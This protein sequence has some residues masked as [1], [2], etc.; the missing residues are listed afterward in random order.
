LPIGRPSSRRLDT[1]IGAGGR[2]VSAGE[3]QLLGLA[4]V[5]LRDPGLVIL[6]EPSSRLDLATQRLVNRAVERLLRGR[7]GLIVAHRLE[8]LEWVDAVLVLD[9]GAIVEYGSRVSLIADGTSRFV[10][11]LR[12]REKLELTNA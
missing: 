5:F 10:A 8:T 4:R 11:L 1:L 6:D 3:A 9:E 12:S 2:G 7:T